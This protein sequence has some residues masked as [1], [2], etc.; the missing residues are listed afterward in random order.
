MNMLLDAWTLGPQ[1]AS[2]SDNAGMGL[3][4]MSFSALI[5]RLEVLLLL[6]KKKAGLRRCLWAA[7]GSFVALRLQHRR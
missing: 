7:L 6:S 3:V 1:C 2:T 4:S 5:I